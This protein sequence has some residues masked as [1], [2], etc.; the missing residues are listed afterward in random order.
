MPLVVYG[1][2]EQTRDFVNVDDVAQAN[3]RAAEAV[4]ASG[5][6]NIGT[7]RPVSILDLI[8]VFAEIC[9]RELRV[10]H[11]PQRAGLVGDDRIAP[12]LAEE[13]A[14]RACCLCHRLTPR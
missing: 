1:T 3:L 9:G 4:G 12:S 5:A 14:V 6:F 2:G 7:G 8:G 11:E 10:I 13:V